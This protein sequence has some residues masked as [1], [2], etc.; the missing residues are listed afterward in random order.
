MT[1]SFRKF[2]APLLVPL[3]VWALCLMAAPATAAETKTYTVLPFTVNGPAAYGYLGDSIPGMLSSRL[4]W[5]G[6]FEPLQGGGKAVSDAAAAEKARAAAGAD[7]VIW[8]SLTI[9]GEEASLDVQVQDASGQNWPNASETKVDQLIPALKG[10]SDSINATIFKRPQS[11]AQPQPVDGQ[12]PRNQMNPELVHNQTTPDRPYLNP[13]FR[14]SGAREDDTRLRTQILSYAA[15]GMEVCDADGD[16]RN[17]VFILADH[18]VYAYRLVED[19]LE[20]LGELGLPLTQQALTIRSIDLSGTRMPKLVVTAM[21]SDDTPVSRILSFDGKAFKE[22][23]K[24]TQFF[25]NVVLL[26]PMYRPTLVGQM[27]Q[28]PRLFRPGVFEVIFDGSDLTKGTGIS[29]PDGCNVFNFNWIPEGYDAGDTAKVIMLT[30]DEHLRLYSDK[31]AR[32]VQTDD[33]YSGAV[34]GVE[35]NRALPGMGRDSVTIGTTYYIPMRMAVHSFQNDGKY[36]VIVNKPITTAGKLFD[37]YRS[38]PE[39]EIHSMYWDGIGLNLL[40]KTRRIKGSVADYAIVDVNNDGIVDLAAV[41][42]T[43]PGAL[44]VD[45]RKCMVVFYPLDLSKMDPNATIHDDSSEYR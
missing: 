33:T 42:N 26:P 12:G 44:G 25:L 19:R 6:Y 17:E 10:V 35:I 34:Q 8:G 7:F 24:T 18:T 38:F 15:V 22:E 9:V 20:P 31:G 1:P 5:Q 30:D 32:M 29:L 14:Y 37:R 27:A 40:W 4:F 41:V 43:H 45:Q 36:E 28:P 2:L 23:A 3:L 11:V 13:Q 21:D 39:S 16:G